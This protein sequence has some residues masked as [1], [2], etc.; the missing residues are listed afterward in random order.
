METNMTIYLI[1]DNN[2]PVAQAL[3]SY[4]QDKAATRKAWLDW[5]RKHLPPDTLMKEWSD[6]RVAGFTFPSGAPKGWKKP[7]KNGTCW[8]RSDNKII[9]IMPDNKTPKRPENY[10]QEVGITA[11]TMI[12]EKNSDGETVASWGIGNLLNPVQ[13]IWAGLEDDAPKGVVTPNYEIEL[14]KGAERIRTGCVME[15]PADFDWQNLLPGCRAI[16]GYEWDYLFGKWVD[17]HKGK[18]S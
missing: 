2:S 3:R 14:K 10:F 7:N 15:P 4:Q 5:A 1:E 11:P 12:R 9:K 17:T 8:P 16:P 6:G 13:F 18:E